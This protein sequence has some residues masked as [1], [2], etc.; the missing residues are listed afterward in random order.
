MQHDVDD[1]QTSSWFIL[2]LPECVIALFRLLVFL[3][4]CIIWD[5][6]MVNN[7]SLAL[8]DDLIVFLCPVPD[9]PGSAERS[10]VPQKRKASSPT[11]S[12]NGHSPSDTSPSPLK[13]KKKPGAVN[14]NNKDQ[15]KVPVNYAPWQRVMY[16]V[17]RFGL[18]PC[19]FCL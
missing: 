8:C 17:Q 4:L 19:L 13:K 7:T 18:L 9:P 1:F 11:H 5:L 2:A 6:S 15:V 3:S 10:V 14:C 16:K 12:S